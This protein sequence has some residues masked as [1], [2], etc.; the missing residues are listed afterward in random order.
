MLDV[1]EKKFNAAKHCAGCVF[2]KEASTAHIAN[3]REIL[4]VAVPG[5]VSTAPLPKNLATLTQASCL[6]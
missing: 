5:T 1:R 6:A 4:A 3:I 2:L